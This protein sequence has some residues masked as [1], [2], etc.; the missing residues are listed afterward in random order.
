MAKLRLSGAARND[1]SDIRRYSLMEFDAD[2]ANAYFRGFSHAFALLRERPFAGSAQEALG[3]AI[4]CLIHK[5]HRIFYRVE[6]EFV[7]IVR[8]IHHARS[9]RREL[10]A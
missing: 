10:L 8:I 2:I 4:R 7:L 5:R 1:L 6:G 3:D 9:A